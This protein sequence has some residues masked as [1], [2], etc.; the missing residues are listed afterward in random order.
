[1]GDKNTSSKLVENH[2][3]V[4]SQQST[5]IEL[6]YGAT[7]DGEIKNINFLM[8]LLDLMMVDLIY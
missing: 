1:M 5:I 6:Y 4:A 3:S 7:T 2:S 8:I